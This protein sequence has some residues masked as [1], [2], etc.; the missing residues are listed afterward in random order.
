ML[1]LAMEFSRGARSRR[2]YHDDRTKVASGRRPTMPSTSRKQ[3]QSR[4]LK[5]EQ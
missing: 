5:T 2:R 4:S 1:V 3:R